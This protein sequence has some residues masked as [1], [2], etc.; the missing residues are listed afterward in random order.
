MKKI[1]LILLIVCSFVFSKE[2]MA[3]DAKAVMSGTNSITVGET[4]K[5]YVKLNTSADFK[6]VDVT[7]S[8]TE[9]LTVTKVQVGNGLTNIKNE[10]GRY[11]LYAENPIK[12]GNNI[13]ILT[14]KGKS[15]GEGEVKITKIEATVSDETVKGN[16]E[17]YK[18]T[19]KAKQST[20]SDPT[21]QPSDP[22]ENPDNPSVEVD[23]EAINRATTLVEAAERS[24]LEDDYLDALS[25]VNRLVDSEEKTALLNRL[26][27]VKYQIDVNKACSNSTNNVECEKCET[28]DSKSW[29]ILSI[30]LLICLLIESS[31]LIYSKKN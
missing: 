13:L 25:Y 10:N 26:S 5:I 14:V 29:I 8:V 6:G 27:D 1:G 23:Q 2:V 9:N 22:N 12:S 30:V 4:T 16:Q 24:L 11:I 3:L 28:C 20:P 7:Y 17:S 31:Y 15:T 18:V 19:V 21:I